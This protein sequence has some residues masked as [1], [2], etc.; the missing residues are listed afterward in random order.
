MRRHSAVLAPH[1]RSARCGR[2]SCPEDETDIFAPPPL[3]DACRSQHASSAS[4]PPG[5][6]SDAAPSPGSPPSLSSHSHA[7]PLR[8]TASLSPLPVAA[9]KVSRR[10]RMSESQGV[11]SQRLD[12]QSR[13]P[14]FA[15]AASASE[16]V[17]RDAWTQTG[18]CAFTPHR[19][20]SIG[21]PNVLA[22]RCSNHTNDGNTGLQLKPPAEL[23]PERSSLAATQPTSAAST[24][25][26]PFNENDF[27]TSLAV[28]TVLLHGPHAH[29]VS[30][31][32][33]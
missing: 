32:P 6:F 9:H 17:H 4:P 16:K 8:S 23:Q 21:K 10:C 26:I 20:L 31:P 7:I 24:A 13:R 1:Q 27:W 14:V 2:G 33:S 11:G 12:S 29:C 25:S 30:S 22:A 3:P 18:S 5:R 28:L 15:P 19:N